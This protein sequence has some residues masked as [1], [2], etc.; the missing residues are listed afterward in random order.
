VLKF[1]YPR[2]NVPVLELSLD[3]NQDPSYHFELGKKLAPLRNKN[4]LCIGSGNMVHNLR[5]MEFQ[6]DA[7]PFDWA[8]KIDQLF[9]ECIEKKDFSQLIHYK[10][11]GTIA[12]LAVPT[13]DHYLPLLY[14]LAMIETTEKAEFIH[15]SIQNASI[16]MRSLIIS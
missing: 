9:K 7:K 14:I 16:S 5:I 1:L 8:I 4:I 15:E 2:Q 12:K 11:L 10:N 6:E 13:N 3:I